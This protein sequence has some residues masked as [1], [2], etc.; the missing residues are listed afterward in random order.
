[1]HGADPG[2]DFDAGRYGDDHAGEGEIGLRVDPDAGHEQM[3]RPHHEADDADRDDGIDHAE[4]AEDRLL[5]EGRD[6]LAHDAEARQDHDVNLGMA[7]EPEE[8][9][10]EQRGAGVSGGEKTRA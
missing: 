2:K 7:E 9:L 6:D 10:P 8:M 5:R 3:V 4:I 1:M